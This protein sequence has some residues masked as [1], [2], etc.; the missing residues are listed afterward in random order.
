MQWVTGIVAIPI[1]LCGRNGCW[2]LI[3]IIPIVGCIVM[4]VFFT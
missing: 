4:I 3:N 2:Q 1:E